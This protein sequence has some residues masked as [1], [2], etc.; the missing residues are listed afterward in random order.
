MFL[1]GGGHLGF[2]AQARPRSHGY[3]FSSQ[4]YDTKME[5]GSVAGG[6]AM[7]GQTMLSFGEIRNTLGL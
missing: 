7:A 4:Q 6:T 5:V 1:T 3:G 2:N